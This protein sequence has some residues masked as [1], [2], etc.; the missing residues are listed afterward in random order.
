MSEL[1]RA[2]GIKTDDHDQVWAALFLDQC[3]VLAM[4]I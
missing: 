2:Q 4:V 3:M 1:G